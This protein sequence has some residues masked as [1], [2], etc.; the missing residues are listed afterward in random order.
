MHRHYSDVLLTV[1][2][3]RCG[4]AEEVQETCRKLGEFFQ[5]LQLVYRLHRYYLPYMTVGR[6]PAI[7]MMRDRVIT[8]QEALTRTDDEEEPV[9]FHARNPWNP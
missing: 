9:E 7:S 3:N 1:L 2:K 6:V 8:V 5:S 4:S